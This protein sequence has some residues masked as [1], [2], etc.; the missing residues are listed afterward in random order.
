MRLTRKQQIF[1]ENVAVGLSYTDAYRQA[2]DCSGSKPSTV[3]T[4]ASQPVGEEG[5]DY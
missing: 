1:A 3:N 5:E 2:Y 4:D